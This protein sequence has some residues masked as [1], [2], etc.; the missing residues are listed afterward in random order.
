MGWLCSHRLWRAAL[1]K[2][3]HDNAPRMG[4]ALA[5]YCV[6]SAAPLLIIAVALAEIVLGQEAMTGHLERELTLLMG[7]QGAEA[8]Q[9]LL[10]S[11][12]RERTAGL[13]SS[14]SGIV[15][16]GLG[17]TAVF[18]ELQA[19]MNVVWNVKP[20]ST[21]GMSGL[22][23]NRLLSFA[24]VLSVAFLLLVSLIVSTILTALRSWLDS[25]GMWLSAIDL[26]ISTL[27][28]TGLFMGIFKCLPHVAIRW[29]DTWPGAMVTAVLF[30]LGK[31][32]FGIYLGKSAVASA[33]GA[34]GSAIVVLLWAYYSSQ[35]LLFGAEF[36]YCYANLGC[37]DRARTTIDV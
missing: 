7:R 35:I 12:E 5:F 21:W 6:F 30:S 23:R 33:Y 9:A 8:V 15:L 31:I 29:R 32:L 27:V 34:A 17:S 1:A 13:Y 25:P 28:T 24:M 18:A 16:L 36:T 10:I 4:A 22:V 19:S 14:L 11:A 26:C 3:F 37:E 20:K 2:F